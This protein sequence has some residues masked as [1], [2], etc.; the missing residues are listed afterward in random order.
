MK[1]QEILSKTLKHYLYGLK[2]WHRY[3]DIAYPNVDERR[4]ELLLSVSKKEDCL[5][6]SAPRRKAVELHHMVPLAM[7]LTEGS[8][9]DMAIFDVMNSVLAKDVKFNP[10]GTAA[11]VVLRRTK[12]CQPG[13][14]Q[15]LHVKEQNH[16]LC[17]AKALRRRLEK[18][19][20]EVRRGDPA[21]GL[22]P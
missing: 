17:P 10:D 4:V 15:L 22:T 3:H 6:P 11:A 14:Y 8:D 16:V 5:Q 9:L 19:L 1:P 18:E 20:N 13:G 7:Q 12:T 21:F 2:A